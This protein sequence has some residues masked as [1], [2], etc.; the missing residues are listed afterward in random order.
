MTATTTAATATE[1]GVGN[2]YVRI[3]DT[4]LRDGE[5]SPGATMNTDEKLEVAAALV[6][7]GVDIIEA[8]FPIASPGDL[9]AVK[10]IAETV[11]GATIA[12]LARCNQADIDAAAEA[13][14]PAEQPRIH[15][16]MATSDIH[17]KHKFR[18]TREQVTERVAA[19]VKY[20]RNFC[21]DIEFSAEDATRSD[22]DFLCQVVE[23][24]IRNG[25][26]TINLPDTVGYTLP[27]EYAAM[28]TRVRDH[29]A[30]RLP[31]AAE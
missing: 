26:T 11:R 17:L 29:I 10:T 24:A 4:T 14:R 2:Q 31:N 5:Q 6:N 25:A 16:F 19:M 18:L 1:D 27:T 21:A 12:G 30:D 8:G 20:A 22:L 13:L 15:V 9:A 23:I 3:F 7:L 28:F